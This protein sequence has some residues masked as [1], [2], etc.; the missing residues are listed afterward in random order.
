MTSNDQRGPLILKSSAPRAIEWA[1]ETLV[2]GGVI[3]IPTDTV[4][5]IAASIFSQ[6]AFSMSRIAS[7]CV[8]HCGGKRSPSVG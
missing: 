8:V 2:E 4:Y 5:G 7:T 1:T 3:A 6:P